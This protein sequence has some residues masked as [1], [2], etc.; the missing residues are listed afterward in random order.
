MW[1]T[2][3]LVALPHST[4]IVM[5]AAFGQSMNAQKPVIGISRI[6]STA[7]VDS[8]IKEGKTDFVV[9]GRPLLT[10]LELPLKALLKKGGKH[11][12]LHRLQ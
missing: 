7:L 5:A 9:M 11:L 1:V 2:P 10:D 8:F 6:T 3:P 12:Y 4:H